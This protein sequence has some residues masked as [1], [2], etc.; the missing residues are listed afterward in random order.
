MFCQ[1][2]YETKVYLT[3]SCACQPLFIS[4]ML[5]M[6]LVHVLKR[7]DAKIVRCGRSVAIRVVVMPGS[8]S[9]EST[10][11]VC[12]DGERNVCITVDQVH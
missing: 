2:L 11:L 1:F 8:S 4:L 3:I 9:I 5:N 6:K 7:I 10:M 12:G